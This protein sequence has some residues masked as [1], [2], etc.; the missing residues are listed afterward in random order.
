MHTQPTDAPHTQTIERA[1]TKSLTHT[2]IT[3]TVDF[4]KP[5][6][7]MEASMNDT[8]DKS[9]ENNTNLNFEVL[10][11]TRPLTVPT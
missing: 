11:C 4:Q 6:P 7:S 8:N 1:E 10:Y 9:G 5:S 2:S 3:H